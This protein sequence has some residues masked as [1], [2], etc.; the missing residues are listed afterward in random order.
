MYLK[1]IIIDNYGSIENLNYKLPFYENGNPKPVVLIGKNGS[2]KTLLISNLI[3]SIIEMK[4]RCYEEIPETDETNY[5]RLGS[6]EY[7]KNGTVYSYIKYLFTDD[8]S[9]IDLA[10][11]DYE[12]IKDKN[13]YGVKIDNKSLKDNGFYQDINVGP[14]NK[15]SIQK[16]FEE[17]AFI[18]LPV[19]R[20]YSPNWLN[21][22]NPKVKFNSNY[23]KYI[24]KND[25]NII[26]SNLLEDIES[27]LLDVI[28]DKM[29]YEE[30]RLKQKIQNGI[31]E[32]E[33]DII[34][35][36][37]KNTIIQ[38]SINE[39]LT[40]I[41]KLSNP[42]VVSARIGV[43]QKRGRK[44]NIIYFDGK[45]EK[46][47]VPK[48]SNLSSGEVMVLG[49]FISILKEF[50]RVYNLDNN[51]I[52]QLSGIVIIDEID[53]HLHL[54]F[55]RIIL[56]KM[57]KMFP[58]IQF[59][60]TS[61]SPF[62]LLGMK[63]IFDI[64]CD[65]VNM[66]SGFLGELDNFEEIKK[67]YDLVENDYEQKAKKIK[68]Y[69]NHL[70][71]ISKTIIITEGKTDWK[72]I[73]KAKE[74][75]NN[76]DDFEFYESNEDMGDTVALNMLK[77][78]SRISNINKR[79]FIFDNDNDK[80]IKEVVGTD[81]NYKDWGNNVYSFVI[82]KPNI[83]FNEEKI[84]IEH[85][86][87]DEILKKEILFDDGITRRI[88]CGND[89][90]KTGIN[91]QLNKRCNKKDVCGEN[92]IRVLS[93]SEQEKVYDLDNESNNSTNYA[94]TKD[95]FFEKVVNNDE[96][97]ID[98]TKFNLILNIIKEINEL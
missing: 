5:Y 57:I 55:C 20:Y 59:I 75:L 17:N 68:E 61:H 76:K 51:R 28:I 18:Y 14:T 83:R 77:G 29:L 42:S 11:F 90:Q 87:P 62:F 26:K 32:F 33:K 63:E 89:F 23:S 47:Y 30:K 34:I 60:I 25:D 65:F 41:L 97:D 8:I 44:I 98:M 69:E 67:M 86:Y 64:N 96:N 71:N 12:K 24:G 46:E 49:M 2:G 73:K 72:H 52:D 79:I 80:I 48:F 31:K 88:Y 19:D 70:S 54:D 27:W 38:E 10:T 78:Q 85:Y 6:K 13:L 22:N 91:V 58:K 3:H 50:D 1:E 21:S 39:L 16:I 66:P 95:E 4:R 82:P 9:L 37:G 53:A 56:P 94:L 81:G 84:S 93:G 43:S 40:S 35:Y 74:K 15:N 36:S 45:E 92:I 7:I